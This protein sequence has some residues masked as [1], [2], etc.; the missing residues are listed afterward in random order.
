LWETGLASANAVVVGFFPRFRSLLLTDRIVRELPPEQLKLIVLHEVAHI[1]RG[2][3]WLRLLAVTPG[4]FVAAWL[5][6]RW[7]T[8]P[9]VLVLSNAAAIAITLGLLRLVS[10]R[11]EFDADRTACEL[12]LQTDTAGRFGSSADACAVAECLGETLRSMSR[13]GAGNRRASWLHPSVDARYARLRS[14]AEQQ[15]AVQQRPEPQPCDVQIDLAALRPA[16]FSNRAI[17][18]ILCRSAAATPAAESLN[19]EKIDESNRCDYVQR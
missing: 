5:I 3:L 8:E 6:H 11:T 17:Q 19:L 10:H 13:G 4:W 12:A 15:G 7:G 9:A 14:W 16:P 1:L 2:H 18:S